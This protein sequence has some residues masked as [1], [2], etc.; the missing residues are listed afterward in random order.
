METPWSFET[1][2]S[3]RN[4]P[5]SSGFILKMETLWSSETSVF[6]RNLPPSSGFTLKMETPWSSDAEDLDLIFAAVKT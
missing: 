5:P 1:L 4:L 3:Y 6:Y 2:V